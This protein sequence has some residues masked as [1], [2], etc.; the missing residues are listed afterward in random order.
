MTRWIYSTN[1]KDIGTLYLIFAIFSGMIGT[2][3]SVL[4]RMELTAPGVQY[5]GGNHQLYNVLITAHAFLMIF[6]LV[7]PAFIGGFGNWMV[8]L[9]IGAPDM[10][11]P[12][13]NNISFWLLPPSLILLLCSSFVEGGAG[14]GWTVLK[15]SHLLF[16]V[17]PKLRETNKKVLN[18]LS[19]MQETPL[20]GSSYSFKSFCL[21]KIL[22]TRGQFARHIHSACL[23]RLHGE[24]LTP[25]CAYK[26]TLS[27]DKSF[28]NQWLVGFTDGDGTFSISRQGSKWSLT[29]Q[30][31]QSTYNIRVLYYIKSQLGVGSVYSESNRN[32]SHYRIR[33]MKVISSVI[34]PIFDKY[35]LLTSKYLKYQNFLKVYNELCLFPASPARDRSIELIIANN[36][37]SISKDNISSSSPTDIMS[38]NNK[39]VYISPAWKIVN[40]TLTNVDDANLVM[41]KP[42]LIGFT[43]AEG[44]FY[45]VKKSTQRLVH[46]FEITQK[47]DPIVLLAIRYL[48]SIKT[49]VKYNKYGFYSIGTT[50]SRAIE[51]IIKYFHSTMKGMKSLEYRIWARS[52]LKYK[53]N[54]EDLS[55]I[56]NQLR[57]MKNKK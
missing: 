47:L 14:T 24:L 29:F 13:L 23:Q 44:S 38:Q 45:L 18:K 54:F 48:L 41:S 42:W 7:M 51:N 28:F 31:S 2:G 10:A 56:Q 9:L 12:R 5:L 36:F 32:M 1:H 39:D 16:I 49:Q 53:G 25:L 33:D 50:N 43:E 55:K 35:P 6:F 26:H 20:I 52:Y 22:L 4:I 46:G 57:V 37:D 17:I 27:Q 34:F 11:F 8:P 30:I 19:S 21:V 3:F 40:N 15:Q